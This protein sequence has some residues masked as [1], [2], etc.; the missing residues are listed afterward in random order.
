M[1]HLRLLSNVMHDH[2]ALLNVRTQ[3]HL[4]PNYIE[5]AFRMP[6]LNPF[7]WIKVNRCFERFFLKS[8]FLIRFLPAFLLPNHS[9]FSLS[10]SQSLSRMFSFTLPSV[11]ER[12]A[13]RELQLD[14]IKKIQRVCF[15][16]KG[17]SSVVVNGC[18][19]FFGFF[20]TPLCANTPQPQTQLSLFS[21]QR[22][23]FACWKVTEF[24]SFWQF[25]LAQ[26]VCAFYLQV[27]EKWPL[28][29]LINSLETTIKLTRW[30]YKVPLVITSG[31]FIEKAISKR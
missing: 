25:L 27:Y 3:M 7:E 26:G 6:Y 17:T 29:A 13:K 30:A 8:N 23:S 12:G 15:P 16:P 28:N 24:G 14:K 10:L 5:L 11:W 20:V 21:S 31:K 18:N 9:T 19:P 22:S 1:M 2:S 4:K